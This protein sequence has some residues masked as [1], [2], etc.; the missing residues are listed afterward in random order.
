M[1]APPP[2]GTI[3]HVPAIFLSCTTDT[4]KI[5]GSLF[6][7]CHLVKTFCTK[8]GLTGYYVKK[9]G[10]LFFFLKSITFVCGSKVFSTNMKHFEGIKERIKKSSHH[11]VRANTNFSY[12][13]SQST[14]GSELTISTV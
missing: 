13:L 9:H 8:V 7:Q 10:T 6:S 11:K 1:I 3:R 5:K 2:A 14:S 12:S 4:L